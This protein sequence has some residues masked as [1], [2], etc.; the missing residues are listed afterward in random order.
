MVGSL[1]FE[2]HVGDL[3]IRDGVEAPWLDVLDVVCGLGLI[4]AGALLAGPTLQRVGTAS[5][6]VVVGLVGG[7]NLGRGARERLGRPG[8][9]RGAALLGLLLLAFS[10]RRASAPTRL[11]WAGLVLGALAFGLNAVALGRRFEDRTDG[12]RWRAHGLS[13]DQPVTGVKRTLRRKTRAL[14]DDRID[15]LS[16]DG[17][18]LNLIAIVVGIIAGL[19]AVLFRL[20]IWLFQEVF[21]GATLNP[22]AVSFAAID[23]PN[24]FRALAPLG[25]ARYLVVP[26]VGG[27]V[28]GLVIRATTPAVRGHG[29]P[30]VLESLMTENGRIQPRIALYKTM[31]SSIAIGSGASLGREGP[32]VQIGSASGSY[33]GRFVDSRYTRTLVAAGA[34]G[35]I[36]ATFNTPIAGVMFALEILLAEYYLTN[37]VVVVLGAVTATAV[38]RTILGFTP[39]PG[40]HDFLV[41]VSYQLVS[42]LVEYPLYI[43]LGVLVAFVGAGVVKLLYATEHLFQ[44]RLDLPSYVKP[45]IGGGLLGLSVLVAMVVLHVDSLRSAT[46]LFGVGYET[47]HEGIAGDLTLVILVVLALMKAVGFALSIGSGSSGGVFSPSLYIGAMV[48]GAFGVL[49]N[50]AIPGTAGAGAYALVGT[51]GVFAA[52]ASAPLTATLI[53][54]ELTGQYTIILPL[55]VVTVVGSEVAQVL[56]KGGTIYTEKLRDQGITVQE[57]R[58][59]S[60]EDLTAKDVMT[61]DVDAITVGTPLEDALA[62]FRR[63]S[64]RGVP[65]VDADGRV[66]GI[67]VRSDLEDVLRIPDGKSDGDPIANGGA[68]V[69]EL[70]SAL[71][72]DGDGTATPDEDG[73][74]TATP[75]EDGATASADLDVTPET[76]V[77]EIGV[78]D[79]VTATPTTNLLTLVDRMMTRNVGRIPIVDDDDR[80]EGIVTR[81]DVIAAYDRMPV[82]GIADADAVDDPDDLVATQ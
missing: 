27:L 36:A 19:G 52:A 17:L 53:I 41:P 7:C 56:L 54:F 11:T 76:P 51:A 58:I 3:P 59:G 65:I 70:A 75:D 61:A 34:G 14:F 50:G 48:G 73:D 44:N 28:V 31:A 16:G 13:L 29:V 72:A 21:F 15:L 80:I 63:T 82:D 12:R 8:G 18:R 81:T 55:L 37:V 24:V 47:I 2:S 69:G 67:L 20:M 33:F 78:T 9:L 71:G 22:G 5:V 4:M 62:L 74:G 30:E 26:A 42:P 39:A 49:V 68:V 77:E 64:H 23:V 46:W 79:V 66:E 25:P 43:V 10:L 45:A 57:R 1:P 40:V 32:I 6:G 38:A 60:L 35:G